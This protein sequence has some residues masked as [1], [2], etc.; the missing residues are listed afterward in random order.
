MSS[1]IAEL[2][3]SGFIVGIGNAGFGHPC[4]GLGPGERDTFAGTEYVTRIVPHRHQ[5]ELVDGNA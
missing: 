4:D 1:F 5:D 3:G 2:G